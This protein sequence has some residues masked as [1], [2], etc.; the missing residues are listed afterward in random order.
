[1]KQSVPIQYDFY[2]V[3]M[4]AEF[5]KSI[6]QSQRYL[7]RE[8][9][10]DYAAAW[11]EEIADFMS[12]LERPRLQWGRLGVIDPINYSAKYAYRQVQNTETTVFFLVHQDRIYLVTSGWSGRDWQG[13]LKAME[14]DIVRQIAMLKA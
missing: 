10:V 14:P 4:T 9:G 8:Y 13:V 1:M 2:D 7:A 5:K 3:Y 6:L 11:R 12:I